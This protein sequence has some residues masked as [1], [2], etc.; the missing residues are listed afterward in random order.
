MSE[1]SQPLINF[2]S[3]RLAFG[4]LTP[5]YRVQALAWI[6][7]FA[8]SAPRA[9][10]IRPYTSEHMATWA[11]RNRANNDILFVI[12][13]LPVFRPIG[14]IGFTNLIMTHQTAEFGIMIGES[15]CWGKGYGAEATQRLLVYG[16]EL[17]GLHLIW[18]RVSSSNQ[19]G[20]RAYHKAGFREVGRLHEAL[21]IGRTRYDEIYMEC[22]A[23]EF[24]ERVKQREPDAEFGE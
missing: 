13:E 18:L 1:V 16:F 9:M 23:A 5:E 20:L 21:R 3:E 17:L 10:T 6:N 22:L 24:L 19:R 15:S 4:P 2:T 7:D 12:Y 14:E 8:V 11:E